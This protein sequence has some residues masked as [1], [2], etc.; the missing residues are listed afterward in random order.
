LFVI[1]DNI[2]FLGVLNL[3]AGCSEEESAQ[4]GN[5]CSV[6]CRSCRAGRCSGCRRKTSAVTGSSA[7]RERGLQLF[8]VFPFCI[9]LFIFVMY[10]LNCRNTRFRNSTPFHWDTYPIS[11]I[12]SWNRLFPSRGNH[13]SRRCS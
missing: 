3:G 5:C 11:R 12:P 9:S 8:F 10:I 4:H 6:L 1:Y 7:C 13:V 2:H